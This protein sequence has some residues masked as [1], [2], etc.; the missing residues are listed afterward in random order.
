MK[1]TLEIP[2]EHAPALLAL[3]SDL[4]PVRLEPQADPAEGHPE[5]PLM[6]E[7][8]YMAARMAEGELE[9][10]GSLNTP[11][12]AA[13]WIAAGGDVPPTPEQLAA[14]SRLPDEDPALAD[15]RW[16]ATPEPAPNPEPWD[17]PQPTETDEFDSDP[18][19]REIAWPLTMTVTDLPDLP[20]GKTQWVYRG[21][22]AGKKYESDDRSVFFYSPTSKSW[23]KSNDFS[24]ALHHVEAI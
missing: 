16:Q 5:L 24:T 10:I 2:N 3:L 15:V 8:Q 19:R 1:L 23:L 21:T 20:E 7:E 18:T 9:E 22:F 14:M 4:M 17:M 12:L 11:Y 6:P 13:K